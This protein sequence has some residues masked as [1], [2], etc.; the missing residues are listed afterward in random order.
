MLRHLL[1][2]ITRTNE[3]RVSA[4]GIQ[5]GRHYS[6]LPPASSRV[7][8]NTRS[9]TNCLESE[10]PSRSSS[11]MFTGI[12]APKPLISPS[13][14]SIG[15]SGTLLL[16]PVQHPVQQHLPVQ[17]PSPIDFFLIHYIQPSR[18]DP[19]CSNLNS[20]PSPPLFLHENSRVPINLADCL[21]HHL[22]LKHRCSTF[23]R[24]TCRTAPI[25]IQTVR[26]RHHIVTSRHQLMEFRF[27]RQLQRLSCGTHGLPGAKDEGRIPIGKGEQA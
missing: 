7:I 15:M 8:I 2:K 18:L 27:L 11:F 1:W 9:Q 22:L 20:P 10:C 17:E 23:R 14:E 13:F 5:G 6:V 24:V 25:D 12:K 19:I 21:I 26:I 4:E 3:S 16:V